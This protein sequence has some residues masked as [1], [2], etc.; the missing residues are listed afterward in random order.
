MSS[1]RVEDLLLRWEELSERGE[2]VSPEEL[3]RDCPELLDEL[4]RRVSALQDLN[5][6]LGGPSPTADDAATPETAPWSEPG[7]ARRSAHA[8]NVPGYEILEEL[9]R[10][11]M[12]VVYKARHLALGRVV[13][14]KMVLAGAH[15][16]E[17]QRRRFRAEA[18]SA[19]RLSHPHIVQIYEVGEQD[20]CPYL[21]LEYVEG[22]N[23]HDVLS[24]S[25]PAPAESAA[26]VEQLARAADYAHRRGVV[27]RDLKPANILLSRIE[28]R[29][30][31]IEDQHPPIDPQASILDPRVS[32]PKITDFG[33]AKRLD[34]E[35]QTLTGDIVG[36]PSYM[37]PE[38]AA[39]RSAAIG[40]ATD[41]YS[42]GA[43]LY[44]MLAGTPPFEGLSP[45]ETINLVTS[46]EPE[47]P[48]R[49]KPGVPRDLETICLKCLE[50]QPHRRYPSAAA[51]ADD[52][53][54]FL[55]GEPIR[56]RPVGRLERGVKW[57]RRRPAL[58]ALLA[59]SASALL[60]LLVGGWVAALAQSR[61]NRALQTA[62]SD[63][64]EADR[65][66]RRAL[67]RLNVA[68]GTH[69]LD[70]DDLFG[71]LIWFAR[72]L[73]LEED[74]ARRQAH[75]TRIAAVLRECPRL[76]Q[77]WFHAGAVTDVTFSPDGRWVLTASDDHTA[78]VRDAVTGKP[79]FAPLRHDAAVLRASFSPDGGRVVT[80]AADGTARV[81]DAVTGRRVAPL[82]GHRGAVR[83]ARF[84]PD[85]GRVVTA[86][87]DATARVWDADSG[88]PAGSPLPHGGC[89][90]R[91]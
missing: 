9:G 13:A 21:S 73:K 76:G 61:S 7:V 18:E 54:R 22:G 79:R 29:E 8:P 55:A 19:A 34:A 66:N 63:L 38:Q 57:V 49:R 62:H 52:L 15:V 48:S 50:K 58:A 47:P 91:A 90:V 24:Q 36:T 78:L 86:G 88:A 87:D 4:R 26:L 59:V 31:R 30:S 14:L 68:N 40:P 12:G 65:A 51:L 64:A 80:A 20:D 33:I 77:L 28:D 2:P 46:A 41:V 32:I 3:C 44:E 69:Y 10:G 1:D 83:D 89:V 17:K 16:G 42:L 27:H 53:H 82:A 70:D 45:W 25:R 23:L 85:G 11:G 39:G 71:S 67:V 37:A 74:D 84:S 72:A 5:A 6:A 56:A 43:I 60:A 75:R 35:G 81:W